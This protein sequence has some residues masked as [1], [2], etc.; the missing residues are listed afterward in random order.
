MYI[1][2]VCYINRIWPHRVRLVILLILRWVRG[3]SRR[4][5]LLPNTYSHIWVFPI[6]RIVFSVTFIPGFSWL[7]TNG[8]LLTDDGWLFPSLYLTALVVTWLCFRLHR[9]YVTDAGEM[10]SSPVTYSRTWFSLV[11]MS[12][13]V[14]LSGM[15][16]SF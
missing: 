10:Y 3:H 11:S 13:P 9:G 1:L 14:L 5:L 6:V 16:K 8:I 4:H 15:E 12:F 2:Y 7:W